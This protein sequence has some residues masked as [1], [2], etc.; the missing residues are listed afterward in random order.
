MYSGSGRLEPVATKVID[1]CVWPEERKPESN[2]ASKIESSRAHA[3][4][5]LFTG[6]S[7]RRNDDP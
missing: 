1:F 2:V 7:P 3:W 5:H 6:S 4:A